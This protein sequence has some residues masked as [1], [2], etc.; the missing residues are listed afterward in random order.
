MKKLKGYIRRR[1]EKF[2]ASK[3]KKMI[4]LDDITI[5]SQN[6]IGGVLYHDCNAKF[7]S[8]TINL[9]ILPAEF[10][11]FVNNYEKY[12]SELPVITDGVNYP[13]GTLSDDIKIN[14]MHYNDKSEAFE[15]WESRKKRINRDKIFIICIERDGF[16]E[17]DYISF[18]KLSYPKVLFTRNVEWKDDPDC[19]YI[20]KYKNE[21]EVPDIIPY[22]IM[23]YKYLLPKK[24]NEAFSK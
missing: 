23:Y 1:L 14:F 20:S 6:C 9:Y 17:N 16:D 10:F 22:R 21:K 19:I 15:K 7:L 18:K 11:E 13:V 12:F 24:I 5:F 4:N 3:V 2:R 8:P